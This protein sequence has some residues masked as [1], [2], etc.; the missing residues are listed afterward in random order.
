LRGVYR[1][2]GPGLR[3][4][5]EAW[6]LRGKAKGWAVILRWKHL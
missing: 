2:Q 6:G 5:L 1:V 4:R 3:R